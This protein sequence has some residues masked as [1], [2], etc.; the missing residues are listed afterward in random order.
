MPYLKCPARGDANV[1]A[2]ILC[3]HV[4]GVPF[5]SCI[6]CGIQRHAKY[7]SQPPALSIFSFI[8]QTSRHSLSR[9][10]TETHHGAYPLNLLLPSFLFLYCKTSFLSAVGVH[11]KLLRWVPS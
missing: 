6:V 7:G 3:T 4:T 2:L 10:V 5:I 8:E 9:Y 11:T 1:A